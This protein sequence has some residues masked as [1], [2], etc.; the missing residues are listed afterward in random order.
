MKFGL[1]NEWCSECGQDVVLYESFETQVCPE[2]G[3]KILPCRM[4][5]MDKVACGNGCPLIKRTSVTLNTYD[6]SFTIDK[7]ELQKILFN[8]YGYDCFVDE[9]LGEYT[10]DDSL[11]IA[12][13][14]EK[15]TMKVE[16]KKM[17]K[18]T[19]DKITQTTYED[20]S[21]WIEYQVD[22][23]YGYEL[24]YVAEEGMEEV[25]EKAYNTNEKLNS[26]AVNK[27]SINECSNFL[28]EIIEECKQSENEM[29]FVEFEDLK[30]IYDIEEKNQEKFLEE[31]M[32]EVKKFDLQESITFYE[33][34]AAVTVYGDSIT[35]FLF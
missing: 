28:K 13:E 12:E 25:T 11:V 16:E 9:W 23:Q 26:K 19:V 21:N 24:D 27:P 17:K 35:K 33:D 3:E 10:Y 32:E 5:D 34:N 29:W 4:C 22:N 30:E 31:I 20:G 18:I 7:G 6:K 2:C 14:L 8:L 15:N 1:I